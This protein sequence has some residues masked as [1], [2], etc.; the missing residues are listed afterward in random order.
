M[1]HTNVETI[2]DAVCRSLG[3]MELRVGRELHYDKP[4]KSCPHFLSYFWTISFLPTFG[5][6]GSLAMLAI[7][8]LDD[9]ELPVDTAFSATLISRNKTYTKKLNS[10]DVF[11]LFQSALCCQ[12]ADFRQCRDGYGYQVYGNTTA[13]DF[14]LDF[15]NPTIP[16]LLAIEDATHHLAA[17]LAKASR[18]LAL[19]EFVDRW[20]HQI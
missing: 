6:S 8:Q 18:D 9:N 3:V 2:V 17:K 1:N 15:S 20:A 11:Q 16:E 13:V 5:V 12:P 7:S 14:A 19:V 10:D 4:P